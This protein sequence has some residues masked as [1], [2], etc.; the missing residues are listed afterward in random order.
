MLFIIIIFLSFRYDEAKIAHDGTLFS[1]DVLE[2]SK[3]GV[4]YISIS[5]SLKLLNCLMYSATK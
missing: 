3:S 2:V 4:M 5:S 1:M